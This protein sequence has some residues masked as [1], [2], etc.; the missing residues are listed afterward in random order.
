MMCVD[1]YVDQ[2]ID[3]CKSEVDKHAECHPMQSVVLALFHFL[4]MVVFRKTIICFYC[5]FKDE[6]R[7]DDRHPNAMKV[8]KATLH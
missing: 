4:N 7:N 6:S 5:Q 1:T 8:N 2:R 3:M